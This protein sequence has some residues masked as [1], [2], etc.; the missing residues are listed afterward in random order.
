MDDEPGEKDGLLNTGL[1][2][3]DKRI[4]EYELQTVPGSGELGLPQTIVKMA[5]DVPVKVIETHEWR[6][7][8]APE[9]LTT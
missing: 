7:I 2:V 6:Q 5:A 9:D 1:Y 8:T 4:F 3:L